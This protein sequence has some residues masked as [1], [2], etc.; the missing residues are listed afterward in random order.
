MRRAQEIAVVVLGTAAMFMLWVVLIAALLLPISLLADWWL[1]TSINLF[2]HPRRNT[3]ALGV[4]LFIAAFLR[5]V[6]P[7][8]KRS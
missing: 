5:T 8:T 7:T 6:T 3:L 2:A 1:G 4:L